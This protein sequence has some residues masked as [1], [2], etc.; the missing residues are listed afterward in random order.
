MLR[1]ICFAIGRAA[2]L[3]ALL[4]LS[5][6]D[7]QAWNSPYPDFSPDGNTLY[8][9]FSIQPKTL[10]PAKS[11]SENELIFIAAIYEPPYEYNYL[12]R[13]YTLQP[14]TAA[15]LAEPK[16]DPMTNISTYRIQ[17]KPNIYYQQHPAFEKLQM[18]NISTII[19]LNRKLQNTKP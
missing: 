2:V 17:I 16:Y 3:F 18:V 5:G 6:C 1:N 7:E 4:L 9:A 15:T 19:L 11:Y 13:P 12:L 14:L 10:D 8:T